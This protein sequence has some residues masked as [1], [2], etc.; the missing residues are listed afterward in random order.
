MQSRKTLMTREQTLIV[1]RVGV[2]CGVV[3]EHL[4]CCVHAM[5]RMMSEVLNEIEADERAL[6]T[7]RLAALQASVPEAALL[8]AEQRVDRLAGDPSWVAHLMACQRATEHAN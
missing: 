5:A 7:A 6:A 4:G 2:I 8:K 1:F 3:A